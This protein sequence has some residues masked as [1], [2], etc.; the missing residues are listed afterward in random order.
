MQQDS[1][2]LIHDLNAM[3]GT[4]ESYLKKNRIGDP[5]FLM[6]KL[7][8]QQERNACAKLKKKTAEWKFKL[9]NFPVSSSICV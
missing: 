8:Q 4:M 7:I 2:T 1:A 3:K 6:Q 9:R 5:T